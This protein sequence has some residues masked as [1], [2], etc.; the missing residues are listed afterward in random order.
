MRDILCDYSKN[1]KVVS[2]L[3]MNIL[4]FCFGM[5]FGLM[6]SKNKSVLKIACA[7]ALS[8][9]AAAPVAFGFITSAKDE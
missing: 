8:V 2:L 5:V 4:C 1:I 3:C 9:A 7:F 6:Q